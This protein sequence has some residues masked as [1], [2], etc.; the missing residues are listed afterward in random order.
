MSIS[1]HEYM[2]QDDLTGKPKHGS[3]SSSPRGWF[4]GVVDALGRAQTIPVGSG[5]AFG[6]VDGCVEAACRHRRWR[7][8]ENPSER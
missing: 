4:A 3:E 6:A 1:L 7:Q 5:L 8:S 2:S